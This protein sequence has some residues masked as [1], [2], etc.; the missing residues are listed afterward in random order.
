[1]FEISTDLKFNNP[2]IDAGVKAVLAILITIASFYCHDWPNIICFVLYL[3]AATVLL[4]GDF[5]F[6]LKNLASY[7]LFIVLPCCVGFLFSLLLSK[8]FPGKIFD[9]FSATILIKMIRIFFVWYIWNLYFW[10]TPFP[11][12]ATML[13][14]VFPPSGFWRF[15]LAK[16]LSM[17]MFVLNELTN[18]VDQFKRDIL[19]QVGNIF[20]HKKLGITTKTKELSVILANFLASNLQYTDVVEKQ[21]DLI[22]INDAQY[23]LRVSKNEVLATSSVIILALS[24]CIC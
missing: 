22:A 4:K 14:R 24:L 20:R 17:I 6:V 11:A 1:L 15:P 3:A 18:S 16:Y 7:G 2:E 9:A 12:I 23:I 19:A 13:N 21:L 5:R 8:I 10:A